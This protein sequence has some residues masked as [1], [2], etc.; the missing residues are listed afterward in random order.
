MTQT[1]I[2]AVVQA[3][4]PILPPAPYGTVL[5]MSPWN[6]PVLL[7]L[8]PLVDA[9][10]AGNTIAAPSSGSSRNKRKTGSKATGP[11]Q[12]AARG[13]ILFPEVKIDIVTEFT[14]VYNEN[15]EK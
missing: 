13:A 2:K 14:K 7:T 8:E 12:T 5:I 1:E 10:A 6:Y 11:G 15:D 4:R 3:Q 9:L